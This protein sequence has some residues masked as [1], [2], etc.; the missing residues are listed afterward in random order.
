[1]T[2]VV[3]E[4]AAAT[5]SCRTPF[6]FKVLHLLPILFLSLMPLRA[7]LTQV[8]SVISCSGCRMTGGGLEMVHVAG[9]P[10]TVG[11]SRGGAFMHFSGFLRVFAP[12]HTP[13]GTMFE[14]W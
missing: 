6:T 14:F 2:T 7:E 13:S 11:I 3:R 12:R 4:S 8:S 5:G 10:G 1:M 9:Q